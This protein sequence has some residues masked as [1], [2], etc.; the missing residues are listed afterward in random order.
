M[1]EYFNTQMTFAGMGLSPKL[2]DGIT[3]LGFKHPTKVQAQLIPPAMAGKDVI[4][5]SKTGTGKTAAFG[6]P[7]L[8][9]L[10]RKKPVEAAR[11]SALPP[12]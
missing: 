10:D 12:A 1:E 5:Q 8:H 2:L 6:L 7:L 3:K 4:A 11:G 9:Q